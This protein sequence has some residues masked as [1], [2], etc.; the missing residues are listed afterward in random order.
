MP[1]WW[2]AKRKR[3]SPR[4]R[5]IALMVHADGYER[6]ARP[7]VRLFSAVGSCRTLMGYD[8]LGGRNLQRS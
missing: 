7:F 8:P 4:G 1:A 2:R 3:F 6:S 5:Y